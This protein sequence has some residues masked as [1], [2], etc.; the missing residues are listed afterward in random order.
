MN[1][2]QLNNEELL[3]QYEFH[4][5]KALECNIIQMALKILLNSGYGAFANKFFQFFDLRLAE[6]IT[7][8]GQCA[9]RWMEK[10]L[11]EFLNKYFHTDNIDY[12]ITIDTD[13][14]YLNLE[15]LINKVK[16][17]QPNLTDVECIDILDKFSHEIIEKQIEKGYESFYEYTNSFE[18][19]MV[20]KR[21]CLCSSGA[22]VAKK[23]YVLN[24][25]DNEGVRY[26]KPKLKIKG[27][28]VVRSST[29]NAIK[30]DIKEIYK[31]ILDKTESDVQDY[32]LDVKERYKKLSLNE[33]SVISS[34]NNLEKYTMVNGSIPAGCPL[35]VRGAIIY[36]KLIKEL[37]LTGKYQLIQS[38]DKIKY[39]RLKTPNHAFSDVIAYLNYFPEEFELNDYIDYDT[40]F[41]KSFIGPV[42]NITLPIKWEWKK[43]N[44]ISDLFS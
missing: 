36:N 31:I 17:R 24:V 33:I 28:D 29:P 40:M 27:L 9:V 37:N 34:I 38:G 5:N 26:E 18:N 32:I 25:F 10:W 20:M 23:R 21:E 12:V 39:I 3:E 13:S 35:H 2:E 19:Q 8:S 43:K 7:R 16:E 4:N 15:T 1:L 42:E 30:N 6:S 11:N 44:K 14:L 22:F 41:E